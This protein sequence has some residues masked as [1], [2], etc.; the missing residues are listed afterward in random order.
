MR[1]NADGSVRSFLRAHTREAHES[2]DLRYA[3]LD[4]SRRDDYALFL[5]AHADAVLPLEAALEAAG[6]QDV[7]PD[8]LNRRR[9]PS[10]L[11]DL[12]FLGAPAHSRRAAPSIRSKAELW[13]VLYTLEGSRLG[14][15]ILSARVET[16][17]DQLVSGAKAYL[18][19]GA[20]KRLWPSFLNRLEGA[21]EPR[22]HPDLLLK[23]A[24]CAFARFQ[25]AL[26]ERATPEALLAAD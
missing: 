16:S 6:V 17:S 3:T 11:E 4:I 20:R 9:T 22:T 23:G 14:A 25:L 19:H 18:C 7:V 13:G 10:L 1:L 24:R 21:P 12:Q 15:R 8:W 26:P 2:V 5:Q